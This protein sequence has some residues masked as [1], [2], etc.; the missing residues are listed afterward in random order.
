MERT[1][2]TK[3]FVIDNSW[4]VPYSP[5]LSLRFNCQIHDELCLSPTGAKYLYKYAYK[6]EDR[7][8]VRAEIGDE[9]ANKD[10]ISD[11]VDMRSIGSSEAA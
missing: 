10:E 2:L 6:G 5:F 9:S 11:F 7:A 1:T 8:M 4:V 3:E